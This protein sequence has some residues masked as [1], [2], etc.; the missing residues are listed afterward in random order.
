MHKQMKKLNKKQAGFTLVEIAI[1]VVIIG[2]LL[3]GV[4]KGQEILNTAKENRVYNDYKAL[5]A[6]IF[7]YQERVGQLPGDKGTPPDGSLS[8]AEITSKTDGFWFQLREQGII[9]GKGSEAAKSPYGDIQITTG[10]DVCFPAIPK[11]SAAKIFTK[12]GADVYANG[13]SG[14]SGDAK[15]RS[16]SALATE[17]A[18]TGLATTTAVVCYPTS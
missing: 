16:G 4:L 13:S 12:T 18:I 14:G 15:I 2:V 1:V 8:E 5:A 17:S 9:D 11:A 7:F 3:G 6:A 10:V